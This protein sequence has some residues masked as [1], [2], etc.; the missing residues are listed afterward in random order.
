MLLICAAM[1]DLE[2]APLYSSFHRLRK[3]EV[4]KG[5]NGRCKAQVAAFERLDI[6]LN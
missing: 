1:S 3:K 2:S 5:T 6:P 4:K